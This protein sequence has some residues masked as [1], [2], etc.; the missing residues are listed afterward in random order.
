ML[1]PCYSYVRVGILF[2]CGKHL[3]DCIVS[4]R[5]EVLGSWK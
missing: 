3:Y 1:I 2:T 5:G 4:V